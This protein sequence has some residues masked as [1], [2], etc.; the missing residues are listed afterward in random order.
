LATRIPGSYFARNLV[1]RKSLLFQ[2]VKRDFQ[3]RYVGS[4]AGWVWSIIHPLVLLAVYTFIYVYCLHQTLEGEVTTSY[5]LFLF[6]GM[7]P[8]LLFSETVTRSSGSIVEQA[9]LITK[10]MFPSEILPVSIFLSSLV[11]HAMVAVLVAVAAGVMLGHLNAALLLVPVYVLLTG[12]FAIGLG[13]IAAAL[14]V[15]LRDTAQLVVVAMTF[16][17]WLTP[18]F[19][20][21]KSFPPRMQWVLWLNPMAYVVRGYR[22]MLLDVKAPPLHDVAVATGF[23]VGA[24]V[25]G[26][27]FFRQMKKG[28][29]DVL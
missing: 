8:W 9:N 19:I 1:Y 28:F 7:L 23:A 2:L 17:F 6:A 22:T 4:A 16:W 13:W 5:P 11:S 27:L 15:Y 29:A 26:G 24:F 20:R 12:L 3:Q 25:C 10:T 14:Q 21:E 18:I